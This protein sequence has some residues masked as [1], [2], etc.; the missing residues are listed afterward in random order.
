MA[1]K[2]VTIKDIAEKLGISKSTV[3]KALS[4]AT[5]VNQLTK[6]KVLSCASELGYYVKVDKTLNRRNII[7]FIYGINYGNV[8][9][10]GYEVI[11]GLQS[12]AS[13]KGYGVNIVTI[14][15]D[16][17]KNGKYFSIMKNS[18]YQGVFFLGFKP[19]P[20]FIEHIE[21]INIPVVVLDNESESR[22]VAR[23]GC[24]HE[25]GF[26]LAVNYLIS[27]GH[28]RIAF[29]GGEA[30]SNVT[31]ERENVY[32]KIM[33]EK[34]FIIEDGFVQ[35]A[36]FDGKK[37]KTALKKIIE[38]KPTSIVCASDIIA[39]TIVNLLRKE[40]ILVP[41]EISVMGYDDLPTARYCQPPLSSI[42]QNRI[43]L[44]KAA[45]SMLE[46]MGNG[47]NI[48]KLLLRPELVIRESVRNLNYE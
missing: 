27:Q 28:S 26:G 10:F 3:S 25:R 6:E 14:D 16:E 8:D 24:D 5:D 46:Q 36:S 1:G 39:C 15:D 37:C 45:F 13:D 23:I 7:I 44:G 17:L 12:A 30:D 9:Q 38:S 2:R 33:K 48:S 31:E 41:Q 29:L 11:L 19:H 43:Q 34:D 47:I 42:K 40:G 20:M 22:L 21:Q 32:R 18:D 35:Y 4:N